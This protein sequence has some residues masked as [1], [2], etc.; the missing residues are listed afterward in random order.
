[1]TTDEAISKAKVN[2]NEKLMIGPRR[3]SSSRLAREDGSL[4]LTHVMQ[5]CNE[6]GYRPEHGTSS[7]L[8][9]RTRA[10]RCV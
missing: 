7:S 3:S 9:P 1:M 10:T 5:I 2:L 6:Q 8:M 4:S